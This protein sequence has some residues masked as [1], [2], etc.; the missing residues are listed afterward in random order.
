L[1]QVKPGPYAQ[2]W[3]VRRAEWAVLR[4]EGRLEEAEEKRRE[5]LG[6]MEG[7]GMAAAFERDLLG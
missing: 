5:A 6:L 7:A 3:S 2:V 4:A 1:E